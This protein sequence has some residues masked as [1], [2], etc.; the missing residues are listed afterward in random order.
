MAVI[1]KTT[2]LTKK[3]GNK[4]A[5]DNINMT[6]NKGDIYGFIGKNG[7]GKTTFMRMI[8]GLTTVTSGSIS[9]F[10]GMSIWD[11]RKTTGSLI[12]SPGIYKNKTAYEN[13]KEFSILT[14]QATDKEI[15]NLLELVGLADVAKKK[16]SGNFSLGM[17]QR[18]GI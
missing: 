17:R 15:M 3:F 12:E 5:V 9:M 10:D 16:K 7:A 18:L 8:V 6:I 4:L 1:L 14:K 13:L 2:G 11:A